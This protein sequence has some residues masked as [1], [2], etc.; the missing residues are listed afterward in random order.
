MEVAD[1]GAA[2]GRGQ[3]HLPP[4][5]RGGEALRQLIEADVIVGEVTVEFT[6]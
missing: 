6:A 4:N 2:V 5:G 3:Q 1:H